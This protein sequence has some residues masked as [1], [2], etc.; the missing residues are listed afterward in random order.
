VEFRHRL[1]Q[2]RA[3]DVHPLGQLAL[4]RQPLAGAQDAP[5]DQKLDLADDGQRQLLVL[6]FWNV[7]GRP[8]C[9]P[10]L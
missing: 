6:T 10:N 8:R 3:R 5:Q 7:I 2:A 4:G 1:P 9:G